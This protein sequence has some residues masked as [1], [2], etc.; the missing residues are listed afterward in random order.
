MMKKLFYICF[1][2]FLCACQLGEKRSSGTDKECVEA[3]AT[4][5]EDVVEML[6]GPALVPCQGEAPMECMQVKY[7][8]GKTPSEEWENFYSSIEGFTYEPGF[9]YRLEV[10]LTHKDASEVAPGQSTISYR[11]VKVLSKEPAQ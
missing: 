6:V 10:A 2:V 4:K 8:S 5:S 9:A 11:L 3:A 1:T 7:L